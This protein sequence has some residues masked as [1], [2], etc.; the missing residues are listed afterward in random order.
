MANFTISVASAG[1][2]KTFSLVL[3][4]LSKLLLSNPE[5]ILKKTLVIT[6]TNKAC[7]EIKDRVLTYLKIITSQDLKYLDKDQAFFKE[8]KR[9]TK[10]S[11]EDIVKK[12]RFLLITILKNYSSFDIKTLDEFTHN[13]IRNYTFE[14]NISNNFEI[15]INSRDVL[16]KAVGEVINKIGDDE[17]ITQVLLK[18]CIQKI[19]DKLSVNLVE[20]LMKVATL[21]LEENNREQ[22]K[23][24]D[25]YS[26]EDFVAVEKKIQKECRNIEKEVKEIGENVLKTLKENNLVADDF[27]R[28]TLYK[29]FMDLSNGNISSLYN[30][31]LQEQL[32]LGKI[33]KNATE[34]Y[35]KQTIDSLHP[36]LLESYL[37]AK[38][39]VFRLLLG[40]NILKNWIPTGVMKSINNAVSEIEIKENKKLLA[41]FNEI[42]HEQIKNQDAPIIYEYWSKYK[43]FYIDEFQDTSL[44]QW[45]NLIPLINSSVSSEQEG[46]VGSVYIVGDP[47]QAIYG[48]RGGDV[49]QF[50]ELLADKNP[51]PVQKNIVKLSKNF[52]SSNEIIQFNNL[53]FKE[54]FSNAVLPNNVKNIFLENLEQE[55]NNNK[56]G[57]ISISEIESEDERIEEVIDFIKK[58]QNKDIAILVRKNNQ[59]KIIADILLKENIEFISQDSILLKYSEEVNFL[60]SLIELSIDTTNKQSL[61]F[62]LNYLHRNFHKEKELHD[63][64]EKYINENPIEILASLSFNNSFDFTVFSKLTL[65]NAL[66]YAINSFDI[67]NFSPVFIDEF[68]N[69]AYS[70]NKNENKSF[71]S[72]LDYWES[73]KEAKVVSVP[74]NYSSLKLLTIHRS[75]G[76]EFDYVIMPFLNDRLKTSME[77]WL[78]INTIFYTNLEYARIS[79]SEKN[80]QNGEIQDKIYHKELAK[81][82]IENIN[83]LYVAFTRAKKGLHLILEKKPVKNSYANWI[84][85]HKTSKITH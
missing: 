56:G 51:F 1:S 64:V 50:I 22:L 39:K 65:L 10:L 31:K 37:I 72:Y 28:G 85:S 27:S 44:L 69:I 48:W 47:K 68:L 62:I 9:Q 42:I 83:L 25:K 19:D 57:T 16:Q 40:K 21:L 8:L 20:D 41:T 35:K 34:E 80:S 17:L 81:I 78:P 55:N 12:S 54:L 29:H 26:L 43:H 52:R 38:T 82:N 79:I 77:T 2:G 14:L 30:N 46:D 49:Q 53:F 74:E 11:G 71:I 67:Y 32:E 60:V 36:Y 73:Q 59:A 18:F 84:Y 4:Y 24:L 66:E 75:K 6:F 23:S 33:Y 76:L 45:Q 7:K 13:V 58:N 63:F 3:N 15:E 5:D 61:L 70:F